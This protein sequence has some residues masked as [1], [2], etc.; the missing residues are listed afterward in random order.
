MKKEQKKEVTEHRLV[1]PSNAYKD[2]VLTKIDHED[3][4]TFHNGEQEKLEDV[5]KKHVELEFSKV[6]RKQPINVTKPKTLWESIWDLIE[7][8]TF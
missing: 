2:K 7:N 1:K 3:M 5:S 4:A 8:L 6:I